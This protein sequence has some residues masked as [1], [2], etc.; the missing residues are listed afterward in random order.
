MRL[1]SGVCGLLCR[2]VPF[3]LHEFSTLL[4]RGLLECLL[5]TADPGPVTQARQLLQ[6]ER[7]RGRAVAPCLFP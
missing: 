1:V 2:I 6:I 3:L 4:P 5:L 7:V